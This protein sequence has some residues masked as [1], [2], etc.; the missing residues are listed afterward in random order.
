MVKWKI[1]DGNLQIIFESG[2][3]VINFIESVVK[4]P[5]EQFGLEIVVKSK[6]K[7]IGKIDVTRF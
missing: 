1:E 5:A 6:T 3:D 2:E 4:W 7:N